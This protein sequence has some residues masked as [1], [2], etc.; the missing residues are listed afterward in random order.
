ML[1]KFEYIKPYTVDGALSHLR[2][3]GKE[4][5]ILA[6]GTDLLVQIKQ[7][8]ASPRYLIDVMSISELAQIE[9]QGGETR[10]GAGVTL[11]CLEKSP[12]I[13]SRF[14][15]LWKAVQVIATPQLRNMGTIGG[16]LCV[17]TRCKQMDFSHPWGREISGKCY[18]RGGNRCH[19]VKEGDRCYATMGS[20]LAPVLIVLGSKVEIRGFAEKWILLDDFYTGEGKGVTNIGVDEL[21]AQI[22]VPSLPLHA[23]TS[24]LKYR[25]RESL[26]YPI[27]SAA[28]WVLKDLEQRTCLDVRLALGAL[29]SAPIR[30]KKTE[31][32]LKNR[33]LGD[34]IIQ[35]AVHEGMK[36]IPIVSC[37]RIPVSY[38][39]NVARTFAFKAI[40]EAYEAAY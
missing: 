23:G 38:T 2:E 21:V 33:I 7:R 11:A 31:D 13:K 3:L 35:E 26:D 18:K 4:A 8:R 12:H 39:R 19:V 24:Y 29:A 1:N 37:S 32:L 17:E 15:S 30:L 36:G 28:A 5:K 22:R 40:K 10:I 25:W 6:G 16:N 27:V 9:D 34:G 14:R 20:D